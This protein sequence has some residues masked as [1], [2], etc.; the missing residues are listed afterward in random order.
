MAYP[1]SLEDYMFYMKKCFIHIVRQEKDYAE[2]P[3]NSIKQ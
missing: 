3:L 2:P 1:T